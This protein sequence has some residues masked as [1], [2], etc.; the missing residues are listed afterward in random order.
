MYRLGTVDGEPASTFQR[1]AVA[2]ARERYERNDKQLKI[3]L[4]VAKYSGL[5]H[6]GMQYLVSQI[7]GQMIMVDI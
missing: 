7:K 2:I 6:L 3:A 4:N 1:K 5:G